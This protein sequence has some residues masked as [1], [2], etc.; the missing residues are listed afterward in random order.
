[1]AR[2]SA[3]SASAALRVA[4]SKSG[5]G[6]TAAK[7]RRQVLK[8]NGG[9]PPGADT[10]KLRGGVPV[11]SPEGEVV[12]YRIEDQIGYLLRRAH[13]RATAVFQSRIGDEDITPTQYTSLVKLLEHEELSQNRLGRLVAMDKAT[14]Q[15]VVRRLKSRE[16]VASRPDPGDARR[17]LLR[18]TGQGRRM[19]E[20]LAANGPDV[21]RE[22]LRPLPA[23]DQRLLLDLLRRL[24]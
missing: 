14:T 23:A 21:S 5:L 19:V 20:Q 17:T 10:I 6:R 2:E 3:H 9:D 15:G 7:A 22:I 16:L 12:R 11:R 1:M 18:L 24:V 13:Q 4:A 8:P